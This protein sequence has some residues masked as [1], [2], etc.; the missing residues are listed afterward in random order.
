MTVLWQ[1]SLHKNRT[2][3]NLIGSD[4]NG[5]AKQKDA[6]KQHDKSIE[7]ASVIIVVYSLDGG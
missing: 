5:S 1:F 6:T 4:L 3:Y 2:A 7:L